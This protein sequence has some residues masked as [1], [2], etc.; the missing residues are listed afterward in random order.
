MIVLQQNKVMK[1]MQDEM[2]N[3]NMFKEVY[4]YIS[5]FTTLEKHFDEHLKD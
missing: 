3:T 1:T 2:I 4:D 5:Y